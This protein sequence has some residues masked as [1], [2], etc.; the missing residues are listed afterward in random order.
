MFYPLTSKSYIMK[1]SM[2]EPFPVSTSLALKCQPQ[3]IYES[4]FFCAGFYCSWKRDGPFTS[5]DEVQDFPLNMRVV[6]KT[7][8][9]ILK[10]DMQNFLSIFETHSVSISSSEKGQQE[11]AVK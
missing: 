1:P 3:G 6:I 4:I 5:A 8:D 10:Y 2:K 7:L 11:I 9:C